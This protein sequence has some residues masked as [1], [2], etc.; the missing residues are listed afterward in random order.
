MPAQLAVM[1]IK[2]AH[3]IGRQGKVC[4]IGV[5]CF[6]YGRGGHPPDLEL[7]VTGGRDFATDG[8]MP[9][10]LG[11]TGMG[12][13]LSEGGLRPGRLQPA[14]LQVERIPAQAQPMGRR[15]RQPDGDE[16]GSHPC[17]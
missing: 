3:P 12:I 14:P 6:L 8:V 17:P 5:S 7:G 4:I 2:A 1:I 10:S 9:V 13:G 15:Q 11:P 16:A